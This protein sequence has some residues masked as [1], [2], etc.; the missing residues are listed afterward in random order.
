[1]HVDVEN[2]KVNFAQVT[3]A[4]LSCLTCI[5]LAIKERALARHKSTE[6][7]VV[8]VGRHSQVPKAS[9]P[10]IQ[11]SAETQTS[12]KKWKTVYSKYRGSEAKLQAREP[13]KSKS[14]N[15][16]V[17]NTHPTATSMAFPGFANLGA[18]KDQTLTLTKNRLVVAEHDE[19]P[20]MPLQPDK[21][22]RKE[23]EVRAGYLMPDEELLRKWTNSM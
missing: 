4:T 19:S 23:Q 1:M 3:N 15:A 13:F 14:T 17:S 5:H 6:T 20:V 11:Q 8:A 18:K 21:E 9:L 12:G 10:S 16:I 7:H 2:C 22:K